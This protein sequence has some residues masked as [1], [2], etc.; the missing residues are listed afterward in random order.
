MNANSP[1]A[2]NA[3]PNT[4][5]VLLAN[6]GG[7]ASATNAALH[8]V[9]EEAASALVLQ[10]VSSFE[11]NRALFFSNHPNYVAFP[12]FFVEGKGIRVATY[13]KKDLTPGARPLGAFLSGVVLELEGWHIMN[14]HLAM[15]VATREGLVESLPKFR[16]VAGSWQGILTRSTRVGTCLENAP[17]A[18][19]ASWQG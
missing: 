4:L 14:F 15:D 2:G 18:L 8:L 1:S 3:R 7:S 5:R 9:N 12:S 17:A 10:E 11:Q 19:G 16:G 13:V 6:V